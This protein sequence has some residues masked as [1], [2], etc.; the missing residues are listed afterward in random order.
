MKKEFEYIISETEKGVRIDHFLALKNELSLSRSQIKR[1]IDDGFVEVNKEVP[2]AHYKTKKDDRISVAVPPPT[3]MEVLPENIPLNIIYEDSYLVVVNKPQGMVVHPSDNAYSGTLVNALLYHTKDLSGIGGVLRPG[4]VHRLDKDTSGL[5]VV[6]KNDLAHHS[7]SKQFKE[8]SIVKRYITLVHGVIPRDEGVI[9]TKFG[10]HPMNRKK[11]T[12][13]D[14]YDDD[15]AGKEAVSHYRV[16]ERFKN[17][18]LVDVTLKT[19]RTHQIRVHM[20]HL[21]FPIVGEPTYGKRKDEFEVKGQLLHSA[22]LGFN[23]PR[24]GK[25]LEFE[26]P[27]PVAMQEI[28]KKLRTK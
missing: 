8:R 21:G 9:K 2:K 15:L 20:Q 17:Y 26:A 7:L 28:V 3:E 18:S 5:I 11:M 16:I 6:A 14:E 22:V 4:I 25:Y 27:M 12:V 1:L 19:G 24:S 23:H 13:L 10:R